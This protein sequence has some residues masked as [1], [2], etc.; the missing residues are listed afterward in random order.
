MTT[1]GTVFSTNEKAV[2]QADCKLLGS[3]VES[4]VVKFDQ[5]KFEQLLSSGSISPKVS[6]KTRS[7]V[8]SE[9]FHREA[10]ELF[11][12]ASGSIS[13]EILT[14]SRGANMACGNVSQETRK[15]SVLYHGQHSGGGQSHR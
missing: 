13:V 10:H 14:T 8:S 3:S 15:A 1:L 12:K 11:N 4:L 7:Q 6:S 2:A 9:T 5:E